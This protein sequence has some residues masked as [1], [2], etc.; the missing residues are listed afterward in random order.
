MGDYLALDQ[1]CRNSHGTRRAGSAAGGDVRR[2]RPSGGC[3]KDIGGCLATWDQEW[4][5]F[6]GG[7]RAG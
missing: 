2:E 1:E 4:S 6:Y 5:G 3:D 7:R